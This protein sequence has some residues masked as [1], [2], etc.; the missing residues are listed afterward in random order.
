MIRNLDSN[1][2]GY[3]EWKKLVTYMILLHSPIL[4]EQ[5][6]I[7]QFLAIPNDQGFANLEDF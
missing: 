1:N 5:K 2:T 7:D 6:D 4:K 3:I